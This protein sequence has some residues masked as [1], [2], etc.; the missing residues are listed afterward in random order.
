[1]APGRTY[2]IHR[3]RRCVNQDESGMSKI[4]NQNW[5]LNKTLTFD[6]VVSTKDF[7]YLQVIKIITIWMNLMTYWKDWMLW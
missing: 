7:L 5:I 4:K 6:I 3:G 1:M 2:E